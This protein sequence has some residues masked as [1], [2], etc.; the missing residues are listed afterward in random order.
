MRL[1]SIDAS[2]YDHV[3]IAEFSQWIIDLGDGCLPVT[4]YAGESEQ[5]W[6]DIRDEYLITIEGDKI[7]VIVHADIDFENNFLDPDYL[8]K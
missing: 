6:I 8:Q 1:T 2:S 3:D 4:G 7:D 5:F